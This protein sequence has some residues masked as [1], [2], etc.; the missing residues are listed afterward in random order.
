MKLKSSGNMKAA[1][2]KF[3]QASQL[4][5]RNVEYVTAREFARQQLVMEA[6]ERGNKAMQAKKEIAATAEFRQALEYDPTNEFA[7]QRLNDSVWESSTPP[8]R[9]VQVV[10]KS[11]E[12]SLSPSSERKDF[13]FRGDSRTLLTQVAKAYGIT[14]TIDDSVQTR[15]A[16]FRSPERAVCHRDGGRHAGDQDFLDSALRIANV[17]GCRHLGKSPEF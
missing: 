12:I 15:R 1:F 11:I 7:R 16:P 2:E 8:S 14:A 5:P 4:D 6:L 3:E 10:E 17:P 9:A 13:Q